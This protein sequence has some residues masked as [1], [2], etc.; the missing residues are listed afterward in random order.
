MERLTDLKNIMALCER[1]GFTFD[2]GYGQ[3][4]LV[5]P[6]V[7]PRIARHAVQGKDAAVLEIGPGFGV[8]TR[9][10]SRL[11]GKV[12]A[13]EIDRR[14]L[15][16]LDVTLKGYDNVTVV[17]GDVMKL[18]LAALCREQFPGKRIS[19][20]ANLPYNITSPIL[21]KLLETG[22]PVDSLTVMVQKEAAQRI[23]AEPG[24]RAC[25][26]ISLAVRFFSDP[27]ILFPVSRGSFFPAPKVDSAVISLKVKQLPLE[28]AARACF[29]RLVKAGFAQRRK[30]LS[31]ALS[32]GMGRTRPEVAAAL[33][34]AGISEKKRAEALQ[35]EDWLR[36]AQCFDSAA[37]KPE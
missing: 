18:D 26:A 10:L 22:L 37:P 21:M 5:N 28:G 31:N 36:L 23:C 19:V 15:P 6:S 3:N 17:Q 2:K 30:T 29:F 8:L 24:S 35:L 12:V 25:G 11:A 20:A 34:A 14:L 32:A 7:C 4:F 16:A 9:E 33:A 13:V 27:E 1:F